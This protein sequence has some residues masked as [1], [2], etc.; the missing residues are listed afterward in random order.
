MAATPNIVSS[1]IRSMML[2]GRASQNKEIM[3]AAANPTLK[4]VLSTTNCKGGIGSELAVC[5]RMG[6]ACIAKARPATSAPSPVKNSTLFGM[7]PRTIVPEMTATRNK[8]VV[9][10][11]MAGLVVWC[12][13]QAEQQA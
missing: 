4:T 1:T 9:G 8:R 13:Q 6:K 3:A 11:V 12:G 5:C 7:E 2:K 10:S